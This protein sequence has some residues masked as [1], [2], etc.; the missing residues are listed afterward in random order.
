[1]RT[2]RIWLI[3]MKPIRRS[4]SPSPPSPTSTHNA[5][6]GAKDR[7]AV[8]RALRDTSL[9]DVPGWLDAQIL[10]AAQNQARQHKQKTSSASGLTRQPWFKFGLPVAAAATLLITVYLPITHVTK[11]GVTLPNEA[12]L[13]APTTAENTVKSAPAATATQ[14]DSKTDALAKQREPNA[15]SPASNPKFKSLDHPAASAKNKTYGDIDQRG[16]SAGLSSK[17]IISLPRQSDSSIDG[18]KIQEKPEDLPIQPSW[19]TG[20]STTSPA[21]QAPTPFPATNAPE[22]IT[23]AE[24]DKKKINPSMHD[25]L[26]SSGV[27]LKEEQEVAQPAPAFSNKETKTQAELALPSPSIKSPTPLVGAR[28]GQSARTEQPADGS[29]PKSPPPSLEDAQPAP[30]PSPTGAGGVAGQLGRIDKALS[31][32]AN[33]ALFVWEPVFLTREYAQIRLLVR[34]GK[35]DEA[36]VRLKTLIQGQPSLVL[37]AD[38]NLLMHKTTGN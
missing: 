20:P 2:W 28:R 38:L 8:A 34:E 26:Q 4:L 27:K 21:V 24:R 36:K 12:T 9:P 5:D 1:M 30:V 33:T 10:S 14:Q 23:T 18:T 25:T 19:G 17:P 37:P 29:I 31:Q 16:T 11:Q 22:R 13:P 15:A 7:D 35:T 6:S 32:G 3:K